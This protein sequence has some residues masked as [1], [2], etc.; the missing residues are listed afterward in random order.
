MTQ[1][2][3][4]AVVG[5]SGVGKDSVM[6]HLHAALPQIHLVRRA[7]TRA[8]ALGGED[9]EA[10]SATAF[11][12]MATSGAFAL[13]WRAHGLS[14]GIPTTVKQHLN[15]GTDCL[16][17]FSRKALSEAAAIFPRLLVLNIT[18]C[19]ETVAQRLAARGRETK[20]QIAKRLAE[21][22][23]PLPQ[24]LDV[25]HLPNDGPLSETVAQDTA[26][27]TPARA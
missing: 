17:N 4:I 27:L 19:P 14:Y 10:V 5:P 1:G 13:H 12:A 20:D 6:V 7:I 8:P 24:G 9:Y 11:D 21:A 22:E 18:A 26:L 3:L 16:V 25:I 15:A 23:K 2:R